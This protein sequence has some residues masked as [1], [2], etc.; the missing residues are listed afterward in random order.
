MD[1]ATLHGANLERA[2]LTT[3][4]QIHAQFKAIDIESA[5]KSV[6]GSLGG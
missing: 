3:T 6:F 5:I 1:K 4:L 2:N